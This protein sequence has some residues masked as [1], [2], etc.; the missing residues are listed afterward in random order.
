MRP[1]VLRVRDS[2]WARAR[3]HNETT[4]QSLPA[5]PSSDSADSGVENGLNLSLTSPATDSAP[6]PPITLPPKRTRGTQTTRTN[7]VAEG[8]EEEGKVTYGGKSRAL[9]RNWELVKG[10]TLNNP[11]K[12][13]SGTPPAT[14]VTT[15]TWLQTLSK[16]GKLNVLKSACTS[17]VVCATWLKDWGRN[18]SNER[19][20]S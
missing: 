5:G 16:Q 8:L 2:L 4:A 13:I 3:S 9:P 11:T 15:S 12:L 18:R 7:W 20:V 17:G 19:T 14:H 10:S 1:G 6:D